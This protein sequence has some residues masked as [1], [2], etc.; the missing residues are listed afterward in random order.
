MENTNKIKTIID[1]KDELNDSC[2]NICKYDFVYATIGSC[3]AI[4]QGNML[5][6][7]YPENNNERVVYKNLNYT[8][9]QIFIYYPSY[10]NYYDANNREGAKADAEISIYHTTATS[11]PL[12]VTIPI[13][14][15]TEILFGIQ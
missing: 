8:P 15:N 6:L 1:G 11:S 2:Y 3:N 10:F 14:I 13:Y 7:D 4:N 9:K 12:I 5:Q